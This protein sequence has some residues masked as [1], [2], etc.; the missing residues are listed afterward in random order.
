[1]VQNYSHK[2]SNSME[3]SRKEM[4]ISDIFVFYILLQQKRGAVLAP[5]SIIW[6]VQDQL[7]MY[8][9]PNCMA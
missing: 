4:Y 5:L 3:K 6:L 8:R 7:K 1:M 2:A 9:I